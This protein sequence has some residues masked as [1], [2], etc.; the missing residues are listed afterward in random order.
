MLFYLGDTRM[1]NPTLI[2]CAGNNRYFA[3]IAINAG[4]EFGSR[5]PGTVHYPIYFSDQNWTKP[6]RTGYMNAMALHRP[7]L[8]SVMDWEYDEQLSDVMSW[9]EEASQYCSE[10][11]IIPKV[12]S[13]VKRLPKTINGKTIRLGYSVPTNHG[14][15]N[16]F[17]S[18]FTGWPVHLLGGSPA[19]QVKLTY[20]FDVRSADGNMAMKMANRGLF[21]NPVNNHS[22]RWISL[23]EADGERWS[24]NGNHEAFR[25]SCENIIKFWNGGK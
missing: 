13:G 4:F 19:D 11:V 17:A 1:V 22:N 12:F 24:G 15:T 23:S 7:Y 25:R 8:A 5:L 20:Y 10:I 2:F 21:F 16:L 6:D 14:A 9:A 3:E 18:E